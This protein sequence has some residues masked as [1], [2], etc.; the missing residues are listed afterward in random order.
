M[1]LL[2]TSARDW[3]LSAEALFRVEAALLG[4]V[5]FSAGAIPRL[6]P[7]LL[8]LLGVIAAIHVFTIDKARPFKLL[9]R[10]AGLA[11]LAFTVYLFINAT[12][13]PDRAEGLAKAASVLGLIAV[14]CVIAASY[15]LRSDAE[16]RVLAKWALAGLMC[17]IVFLLIELSFDEPIARFLN[18]HVVQLFSFSHKKT[19]IVDGEVTQISA[20]V[21]NR[22]VTS[23]VLVLI[24]GLL[25]T[26]AL[27]TTTARRVSLVAL[28][29]ATAA[30]VLFSESG[31]SVVAF[32]VGA[33]VLALAVLSLKIT[34]T[35]LM[36]GWTVATLLAVPLGALPYELG[37]HHWTWL[38]PESVAAR[39]Y[40]WK[41]VA[42]RV[43][44]RPITGIGIRGTRALHLIIPTDEGDPSH[45]AYALQGRQ[46]R[47]PHNIY[48]QTWLELGAIGA[49]LLLVVGL[50]AL[51]QMRLLP[52]VLEGSSYALFAVASAVGVSGFDLLQT[53]LLAALALAWAGMML[54]ARLP[55]PFPAAF[56][57]SCGHEGKATLPPTR[58]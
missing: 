37:W 46:A 43:H 20:F 45:A 24:P 22:N 18:N 10:P 23:L 5:C 25:F 11:L 14:V 29:G 19:K 26:G 8:S 30:A 33:I 1:A 3:R 51:W 17:G 52:P 2:P 7:I 28:I 39:F 36:V 40:I 56:R 47:H 31:T 27:A 9:R 12:W 44:E 16:M 6:L 55:A 42:D 58:A 15:S 49:V 38:P 57:D 41:Y 32:F 21:L 4:A 53:W 35:L 50:T 13:S 54:A 34:R 48:L